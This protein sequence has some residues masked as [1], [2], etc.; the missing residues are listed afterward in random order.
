MSAYQYRSSVPTATVIGSSAASVAATTPGLTWSVVEVASAFSAEAAALSSATCVWSPTP[1]C[2]WSWAEL[3][4]WT[5][6]EALASPAFSPSAANAATGSSPTT[7][8]AEAN[9]LNAAFLAFISPL[10]FPVI[11]LRCSF[12]I[13]FA[14]TKGPGRKSP[15]QLFTTLYAFE[16]CPPLS[17]WHGST[18]ISPSRLMRVMARSMVLTLQPIS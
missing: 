12:L 2:A 1:A 15:H 3:S 7:S 8:I 4:T 5:C 13:W 10:P 17:E 18:L 11:A 14:I 6:S 16:S 9:S